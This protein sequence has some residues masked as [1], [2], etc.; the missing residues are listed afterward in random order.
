M[1]KLWKWL[2]GKKTNIGTAIMIIAQG[3]QVFFPNL[4]P[5]E[6]L[7]FIQMAG[8]A[9]GGLGLMHKGTKTQAGKKLINTLAK[10]KRQ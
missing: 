10:Q 8:G 6:Q 3:M 9:I 2:S 5:A 1:K 7:E 4:V